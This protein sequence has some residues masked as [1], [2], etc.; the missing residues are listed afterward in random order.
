MRGS[1]S[2]ILVL[3]VEDDILIRMDTAEMM[4]AAGFRVLEASSAEQAITLLEANSDIGVVFTDIDMPGSM[5]GIKLAEAVRGRWPPIRIIATSAH[6][7]FTA[8]DL[9]PGSRFIAKP[10]SHPE[11][12]R[13]IAELV[14]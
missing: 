12:A 7:D 2:N 3:I 10:Y 1:Q 4:E 14:D 5:N 8:D 13:A 6:S 11:V 9:P